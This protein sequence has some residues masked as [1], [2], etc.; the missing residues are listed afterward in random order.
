MNTAFATPFSASSLP[1]PP[2]G[3]PISSCDTYEQAQRVV[4]FLAS[5][6]FPVEDITIVGV[7]PMLVERVSGRLTWGRVLG[8]AAASGAW[9][10]MFVGLLLSLF[11]VDAG[12]LPIAVGLVG[13]VTASMITATIGYAS[14]RG[15]RDFASRSELVARRYDVLCQPRNAEAGRD[16]LYSLA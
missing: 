5:K 8:A 11:T 16:L 2:T 6:S 9:L 13:G 4:D 3:W 7:E 14:T 10:G 1:T 15:R 12:M